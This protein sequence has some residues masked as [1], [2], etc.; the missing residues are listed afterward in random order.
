[1]SAEPVSAASAAAGKSRGRPR[2][3]PAR[4]AI[5]AAA[6]ELM[7]ARGLSAVSMDAIAERA[8][9]SKA[10]IYRWWPT[11][12]TLALDALYA[13]LTEPCP[14]PPDTGTLRGDL[15]SLLLGWL[16]RTGDR[17]WGRVIG[18]LLTE[19][20]TD[21]KFGALYRER[22]VEPRRAQIR[23]IFQ[24]AVGRDEIGVGTDVEAAID[25][26]YGAL[27]HRL[28]HGHAPLSSEFV[29]YAIDVVVS[30]LEK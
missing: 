7:L 10:T 5:L 24:R 20:A 8:G 18:A 4:Q 26:L 6:T 17:P 9:V 19:A 1:M 28:L 25:L 22:Y 23:T 3:E 11:K 12:E 13:E 16:E 14:D 2:S 29:D 30:G 27:Y 21:A 15:H